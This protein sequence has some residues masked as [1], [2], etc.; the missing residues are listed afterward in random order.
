MQRLIRQG[1]VAPLFLR[2]VAVGITIGLALPCSAL[3]EI[4]PLTPGQYQVGANPP[5]Q[6]IC[7]KKNGIWYGTTFNFGGFWINN[8]QNI[9]RIWAAIYGSYQVQG[10][11]YDGY[12]N[13]TI[14][15]SKPPHSRGL[16][17]YWYDWFDDFSYSAF[18]TDHSFVK[19]KRDCDPPFTGENTHAATQ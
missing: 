7:L 15:I 17:A 19:V 18:L 9:D 2:V 3:A 12:G 14:T 16:G 6:E 11:D 8:P 13:S 4:K 5:I 10:H 1:K